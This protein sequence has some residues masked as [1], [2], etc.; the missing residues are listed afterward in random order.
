M[1]WWKGNGLMLALL[2]AAIIYSAGKL[3][4]FGT[5]GGLVVSAIVSYIFRDDESSFYSFRVKFWPPLFLFLAVV[6][7]ISAYR[8]R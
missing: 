4:P 1:M 5:V 8:L 3:G 2:V 7:A 6:T